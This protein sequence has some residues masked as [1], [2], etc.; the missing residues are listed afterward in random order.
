MRKIIMTVILSTAFCIS[1]ASPGVAE[2][3][4]FHPKPSTELLYRDIFISMLVPNI[5]K[6][7]NQYY[8]EI[9]TMDPVV[10]P[11]YVFV[12]D[13]ERLYGFRSFA[14]KVTLKVIP[15]VGPHIQ[16]GVDRL[17]F[18]IRIPEVELKEYEHLKTE[19]LPPH[20]QHILK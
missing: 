15:V 1:W 8:S 11:Y 16:V 5:E 12:E 6:Q 19:K 18:E 4:N 7:V 14:F 13:A 3:M 2:D 17:V 9:L 10:Y 20:W